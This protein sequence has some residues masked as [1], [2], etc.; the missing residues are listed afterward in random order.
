MAFALRWT[1]R[2]NADYAALRENARAAGLSRAEQSK[3]KSSRA[4][5]LFKQVVKTL[6]LLADNPKHPGLKTHA[7]DSL[8]HPFKPGEKVW[9]AYV[10]NNTPGAYRLFWCD[11]PGTGEITVIAIT[12]HP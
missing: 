5:G 9:E 10:Q 4:E 1:P 6:T 7:Y 2:A 11:G 3:S 8:E 12:P